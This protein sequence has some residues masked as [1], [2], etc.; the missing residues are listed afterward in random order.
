MFAAC[1]DSS[2]EKPRFNDVTS[3]PRDPAPLQSGTQGF[4]VRPGRQKTAGPQ[5]DGHYTGKLVRGTCGF[6]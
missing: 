6:I 3:W 5:T 4:G 1:K 2:S